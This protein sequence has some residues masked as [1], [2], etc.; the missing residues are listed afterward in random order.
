ME[1]TVPADSKPN[2]ADALV[3]LL[4]SGPIALLC[5]A[6]LGAMFRF[7][8]QGAVLALPFIICFWVASPVSVILTCLTIWRT[9]DREKSS[10]V[11]LA[12]LAALNGVLL[13][14][15]LVFTRS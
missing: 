11:V 8:G 9:G 12:S 6:V 3:L 4:I 14:G 2:H 13:I 10:R 1:S 5:S 7:D 15:A